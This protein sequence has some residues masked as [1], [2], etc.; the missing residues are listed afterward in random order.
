[1]QIVGVLRRQVARPKLD[2]PG[3]D[4]RLD[5]ATAQAPAA[6]PD[7]YIRH[8]ARL[9]PA[10]DQEQVDLPEHHRTPADPG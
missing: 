8:P 2:R 5:N 4:R 3:R 7:R 6:A 9:A 10:P 1:M